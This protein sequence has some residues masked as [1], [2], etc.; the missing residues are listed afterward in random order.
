MLERP[1]IKV[2]MKTNP[3]KEKYSAVSKIYSLNVLTPLLSYLGDLVS[4]YL[5]YLNHNFLARELGILISLL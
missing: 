1:N 3:R 4:S 2:G 5:T